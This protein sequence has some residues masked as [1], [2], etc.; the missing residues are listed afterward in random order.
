MNESTT[1]LACVCVSVLCTVHVSILIC[2]WGR[3]GYDMGLRIYTPRTVGYL[4]PLQGPCSNHRII[5]S[6][7]Q[8]D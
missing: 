1:V 6:R 2:G 5:E 7:S 4:H 3:V 8:L